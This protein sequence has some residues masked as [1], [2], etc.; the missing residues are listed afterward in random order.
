MMLIDPIITT[1]KSKNYR[2]LESTDRNNDSMRERAI[3][4]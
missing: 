1:S 3:M 4:K 2:N